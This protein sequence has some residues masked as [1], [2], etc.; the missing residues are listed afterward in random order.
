MADNVQLR[1]EWPRGEAVYTMT[2]ADALKAAVL[3]RHL[4]LG[5]SFKEGQV[6]RTNCTAKFVAAETLLTREILRRRR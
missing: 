4:G 2:A 6:M 1:F 3:L 5:L